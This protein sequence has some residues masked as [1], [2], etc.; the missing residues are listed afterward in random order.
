MHRMIKIFIISILLVLI[1]A[2][3]NQNS[4]QTGESPAP[5]DA[6]VV[7]T[8]PEAAALFKKQ[9]ISCHAADLSGRVGEQSNL[10]KV[11][12]RLSK[13]HIADTIKN[14]GQMMPA[15]DHLSDD[16]IELLAEWLSTKK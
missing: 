16:E 11:G 9:C 2:C 7:E 13:E 12:T 14:G 6:N 15:Q 3:G 10:Q 8:H 5:S 1:S 4:N